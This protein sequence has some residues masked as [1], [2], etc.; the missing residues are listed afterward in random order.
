[1]PDAAPHPALTAEQFLTVISLVYE[2]EEAL[3]GMH[4]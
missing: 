3:H 4:P 2:A 1:M